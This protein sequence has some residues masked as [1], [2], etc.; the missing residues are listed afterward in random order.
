MTEFGE[1]IVPG[2]AYTFTGEQLVSFNGIKIDSIPDMRRAVRA[3]KLN[4]I[5][6]VDVVRNGVTQRINVTVTGYTKVRAKISDR[7]DITR[8]QMV[9]RDHWLE[10]RLAEDEAVNAPG[11]RVVLDRQQQ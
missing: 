2:F 6:S 4:D 1:Q 11:R 7:P 8:A 5:V 10:G 3:I 9:M